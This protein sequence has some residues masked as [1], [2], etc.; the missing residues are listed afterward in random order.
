MTNGVNISK[1]KREKIIPR[2]PKIS[3]GSIDIRTVSIDHGKTL[4]RPT[5]LGEVRFRPPHQGPATRWVTATFAMPMSGQGV[6]SH[7][8]EALIMITSSSHR[9]DLSCTR[10][11]TACLL[12]A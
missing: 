2:G 12:S 6:S 8:T 5:K 3:L 1:S 11:R 10:R 7:L 4:W 9:S